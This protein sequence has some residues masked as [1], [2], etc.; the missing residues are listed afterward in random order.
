MGS[1]PSHKALHLL[2]ILFG[3]VGPLHLRA[4]QGAPKKYKVNDHG[5]IN[6]CGRTFTYSKGSVD[7]ITIDDAKGEPVE[8]IIKS[9]GRPLKMDGKTIHDELPTFNVPVEEHL[10]A[11]LKTELAQL[12]DGYYSLGV[13][14]IIVDDQG[15]TCAFSYEGITGRKNE[16]ERTGEIPIDIGKQARVKL[17]DKICNVLAGFPAYVPP[18]VNGKKVVSVSNPVY[19]NLFKMEK[20]RLYVK[21][22]GVWKVVPSFEK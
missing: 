2:L 16:E 13:Y 21:R 8:N 6:L 12:P 17:F 9:T 14:N 4:Q 19:P 11:K 1:A 20:H 10:Y 22:A 5:I 3:I 7:T 15:K 18:S